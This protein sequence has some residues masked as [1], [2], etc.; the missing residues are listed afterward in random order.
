MRHPVESSVNRRKAIAVRPLSVEH[1]A[2]TRLAEQWGCSLSQA[3]LRLVRVGLEHAESAPVDPRVQEV[4]ELV[5]DGR[6]RE[7]IHEHLSQ[8]YGLNA[9]Q[10]DSLILEARALL[11][12][13]LE[14]ELQAKG[15]ESLRRLAKYRAE[16]AQ[17]GRSLGLKCSV[18]GSA[19][20]STRLPSSSSPANSLA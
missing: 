3:A 10:S 17:N 19:G 16:A 8:S 11:L 12:D 14:D 18:C 2:I 5:M 7:Q 1:D 13:R 9:K 15:T 4:C 20:G 6:S